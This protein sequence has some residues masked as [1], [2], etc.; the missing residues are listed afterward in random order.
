MENPLYG[1]MIQGLALMLL[2]GVALSLS[3]QP[4]SFKR[5]AIL[6]DTHCSSCHQKD[7]RGVPKLIPPLVETDYVSGD[8][9]RLIQILLRGLNEPIVVLDEDYYSPMASFAHLS[10]TQIADILT[11][12]RKH[13]GAGAGPISGAEVRLQRKRSSK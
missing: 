12:I 7:G 6:Y 13:F 2:S 11:Y 3:A 8:K 1:K 5:G 4:P 9:T 10:D